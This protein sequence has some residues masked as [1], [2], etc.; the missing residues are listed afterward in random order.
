[1]SD[2]APANTDLRLTLSWDITQRAAVV[3]DVS[4]PPISPHLET[5]VP[6]YQL[7]CV[8]SWDSDSI[9]YTEAEA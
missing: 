8:T 7:L 4:E 5:S 9:A 1:M 6:N 2:F 3:T